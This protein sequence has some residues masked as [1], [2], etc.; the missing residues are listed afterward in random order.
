MVQRL[1]H[2]AHIVRCQACSHRLDALPLARQQQS[3]TVVLQ[4]NVAISVPCGFRQAVDVCRKA[5]L[6]WAWRGFRTHKTILLQ[7]VIL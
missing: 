4:W 7:N 6:L 2:A 1:M 3:R 5:S